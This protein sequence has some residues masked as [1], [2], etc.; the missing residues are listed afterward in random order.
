MTLFN[1]PIAL[2]PYTPIKNLINSQLLA[3][4]YYI[5]I[6]NQLLLKSCLKY[7]AN[8]EDISMQ[9]NNTSLDNTNLW[10]WIPKKY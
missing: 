7:T 10:V 9:L 6:Y 8:I 1:H 3:A 4:V 5:I 2:C